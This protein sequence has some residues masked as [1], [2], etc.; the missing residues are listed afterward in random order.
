MELV[1]KA[2]AVALLGSLFCLALR[3]YVPELSLL[4]GI[5]TGACVLILLVDAWGQVQAGLDMLMSYTG[6]D[7]SLTTPVLKVTVIAVLTKLAS[8]I[9]RDAGEGTVAVCCEL[10][11]TIGALAAVMPLLERIMD[12]IAG[13]VA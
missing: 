13:L 2:A 4:L 8:Q 11:G 5:V 1:L 6:L 10:A 7:P 9:C 3:R 12:L